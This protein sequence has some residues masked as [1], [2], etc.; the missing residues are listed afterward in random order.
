MRG[1]LNWKRDW[2]AWLV[3]LALILHGA[4]AGFI[5][6]A[7]A[8]PQL[9]AFG[10][11]ICTAHGAQTLPGSESPGERSHLPDCC[12]LGCTTLAGHALPSRADALTLRY[13]QGLIFT[14]ATLETPILRFERSPLN[15]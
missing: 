5:D 4:S 12:V 15:A 6:G 14:P 9:Y 3:A 13:W 10:N 11:V 7:M 2:A 8:A 1:I